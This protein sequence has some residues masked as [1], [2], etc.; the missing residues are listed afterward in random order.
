MVSWRS[1]Y[2]PGYLLVLTH[3][4]IGSSPVLCFLFLFFFHQPFTL[5]FSISFIHFISYLLVLLIT[6]GIIFFYC[7]VCF[8][9]F[10]I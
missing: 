1:G 9:Y 2:R 8:C 10:Y 5:F 3:K 7:T 4:V 6:F